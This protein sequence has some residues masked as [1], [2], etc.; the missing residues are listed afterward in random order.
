ML[1]LAPVLFD[2][3]EFFSAGALEPS[4]Q[5]P[6]VQGAYLYLLSANILLAVFNLLPAFPM[7]G[8][9]V[10]RDILALRM[11]R[12]GRRASPSPWARWS[13]FCWASGGS[14]GAASSCC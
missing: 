1:G 11:E 4:L 14:S 5:E 8:G 3:T 12:P 7:D 6:R 13:R 2:A 9:R 10:F